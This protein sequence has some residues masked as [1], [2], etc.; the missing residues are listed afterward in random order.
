MTQKTYS[1]K[2]K[3]IQRHWHLVDMGD[4]VLGR[5][6]TR[7]ATLLIG[8]H[9]PV[10]ASHIDCGDYVIVVNAGKL[11]LTGKKPVQKMYYRH[12]G[13]PGGFK[14]IPFW[15][16]MAR[17]PRRVVELAVRGMLPKNKLRDARLQRLKVFADANHPYGDKILKQ[18]A[19]P[20]N[21]S[22]TP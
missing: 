10:Y 11:R 4:Q 14:Q 12:S 9:K 21:H 17:D 3:E 6:A 7:I 22:E 5:T 2:A 16:M 1:P 13:Y 8:K 20:L 18:G 15:K 19:Q